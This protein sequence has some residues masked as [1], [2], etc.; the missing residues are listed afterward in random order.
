[1][2]GNKK[3]YKSRRTVDHF[4]DT[5]RKRATTG[6]PINY[7]KMTV[8]ERR[9]HHKDIN[10]GNIPLTRGVTYGGNKIAKRRAALAK[11]TAQRRGTENK[12]HIDL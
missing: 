7:K 3:I 4:T 5:A 1:M 8:A 11:K 2:S 6:K 12:A 10:E 9:K